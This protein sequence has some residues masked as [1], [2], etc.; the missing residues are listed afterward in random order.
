MII[1]T[2]KINLLRD[3]HYMICI[4][5]YYYIELGIRLFKDNSKVIS[6]GIVGG[7]AVAALL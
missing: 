7:L 5:F 2:L 3:L 1:L 4:I 6:I